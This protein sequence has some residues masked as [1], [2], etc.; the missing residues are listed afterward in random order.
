MCATQFTCK[1]GTNECLNMPMFTFLS[2]NADKA[3]FDMIANLNFI[4]FILD[5]WED[6]AIEDP[7]SSVCHHILGY[8]LFY[9]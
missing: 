5:H 4:I 7:F 2:N 9:I 6:R 8:T 1:C 3:W